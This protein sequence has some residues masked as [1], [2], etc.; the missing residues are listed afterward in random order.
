M[1]GED[2]RKKIRL[3]ASGNDNSDSSDRR[4]DGF[5]KF[6]FPYQVLNDKDIDQ[7]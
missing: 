2:K 3:T 6:E 5:A 7:F 1:L 4:Y